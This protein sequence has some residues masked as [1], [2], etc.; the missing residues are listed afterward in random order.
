MRHFREMKDPNDELHLLMHAKE[1]PLLSNNVPDRIIIVIS[2]HPLDIFK[3]DSFCIFLSLHAAQLLW[4]AR[5][6]ELKDLSKLGQDMRPYRKMVFQSWKT[7]VQ[8][9]NNCLS[10]P[11]N[12][13]PNIIIKV[14]QFPWRI[15][16]RQFLKFPVSS[17]RSVCLSGLGFAV[18]I[19]RG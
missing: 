10:M 6:K 2:I 5:Q 7:K 19:N 13:L 16:N 15:Q 18:N 9:K 14:Y 3:K 8:M 12:N 4:L 11:S 17:G 1:P